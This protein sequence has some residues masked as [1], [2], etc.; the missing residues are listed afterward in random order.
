MSTIPIAIGMQSVALCAGQSLANSN[1]RYA[2]CLSYFPVTIFT[3][4][5][6]IHA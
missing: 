4:N 2:L 5:I 6:Q 3:Q 1:H